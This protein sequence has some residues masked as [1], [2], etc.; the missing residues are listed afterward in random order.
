MAVKC[1]DYTDR[2][3]VA[4]AIVDLER[5]YNSL[6][7]LVHP[8]IV[9][10]LGFEHKAAAKKAFIRMEWAATELSE[11][12]DAVDLADLIHQ[13]CKEQRYRRSYLMAL[14]IYR[15]YIRERTDPL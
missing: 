4:K 15:L 5:E 1:I 3:D 10:F 2:I 9:R 11:S 6:K 8:S 7:S 13:R 12:N 14:A